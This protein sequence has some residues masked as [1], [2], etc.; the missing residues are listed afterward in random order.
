MP[1]GNLSTAGNSRAHR[2]NIHNSTR[3]SAN[4]KT[5]LHIA[6]LLSLLAFPTAG[7]PTAAQ[8]PHPAHPD[9]IFTPTITP[10]AAIDKTGRPITVEIQQPEPRLAPSMNQG[11]SAGDSY[12]IH[13]PTSDA[14]GPC[15]YTGKA[16]YLINSNGSLTFEIIADCGPLRRGYSYMVCS[17]DARLRCKDAPWWYFRDRTYVITIEGVSVNGATPYPWQDA[18]AASQQLQKTSDSIQALNE[19]IQNLTASNTMHGRA[20]SCREFH[21]E[22]KSY[23][24][25]EFSMTCMIQSLCNGMP[26]LD[27]LRDGDL[28]DWNSPAGAYIKQQSKATDFSNWRCW[29]RTQ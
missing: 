1:C 25:H 9:G 21:P 17:L 18:S 14:G 4:L 10:V 7:I 2:K 8:D 26:N 15:I 12:I 11:T 27:N 23:A 29:M 16:R 6:T 24:I 3:E 19:R 22:T 13:F 20:I 28:L 5:T